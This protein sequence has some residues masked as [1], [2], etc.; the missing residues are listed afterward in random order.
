MPQNHINSNSKT[1]ILTIIYRLSSF[2][3]L[4]IDHT[5]SFWFTFIFF[6]WYPSGK[7]LLL[8]SGQYCHHHDDMKFYIALNILLINPQKNLT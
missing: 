3:M 4:V 7:M 5:K 2:V 8:F 6:K 1:T